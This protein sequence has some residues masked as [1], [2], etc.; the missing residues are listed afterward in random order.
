MLRHPP[1][2]HDKV[3]YGAVWMVWLEARKASLGRTD[4][5]GNA[6]ILAHPAEAAYGHAHVLRHNTEC[7]TTHRQQVGLQ[8]QLQRHVHNSIA[9]NK[10]RS[11]AA[12]GPPLHT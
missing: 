1:R 2:K 12:L 4:R 3:K 5:P 10:R 9:N 8:L 7:R 6:R 11:A